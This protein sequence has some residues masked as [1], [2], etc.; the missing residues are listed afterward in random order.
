MSPLT[1]VIA[2]QLVD[3]LGEPERVLHLGL[4]RRVGR[5]RMA[6]LTPAAWRTATP[7]RRR[8]RG[9][10]AGPWSWCSS[11]SLPPSCDQ[12]R[13]I[14]RRRSATAGPASPSAR[15]AGPY[16]RRAL[17]RPVFEHQVLAAGAADRA[18]TISTNR[19]MP[20][21]SCTT[22]SP[23]V[24]ASGST[25]LRRLAASRLPSGRVA[26]LP[27]RSVSVMHDEVGARHH[28]AVVQRSLEH[29]DDTRF[30]RRTGLQHRCGSIGFG[31]LLDERGA[32]CRCRA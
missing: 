3:G 32:R 29:A 20:C 9:P 11:Q 15:R 27:V 31:Q 25:T 7:I 10:P 6:L 19:P 12:R 13:R 21:W 28:H 18:S 24:S 22:R 14:H 8:S 2:V 16:R 30:G 23:A 5:E 17:A 1:S 26:R 4:P